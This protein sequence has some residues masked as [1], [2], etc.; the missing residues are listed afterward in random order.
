[1]YNQDCKE[2]AGD[3]IQLAIEGRFDVIVHGCNC[4]CTMGAGLAKAIRAEFP[5]AYKADLNTKKG[6]ASKLGTYTKAT[7]DRNGNT[8]TI[9]NA[10][11]QFEYGWVG[12]MAQYEA[13]RNVCI[14][15]KSEFSGKRFGFPL[16]GAGL[17]GG[18]WKIIEIILCKELQGED[19]TVVKLPT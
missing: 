2:V 11:I 7:V 16:I 18:N 6:D 4:F 9:I 5:E 1:M 12:T 13:I 15:L 8:I 19:Y 17:A 14:K 10:Y 3:I